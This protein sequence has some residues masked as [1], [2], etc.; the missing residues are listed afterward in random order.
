MIIAA[1]VTVA[2]LVAGTA[3][4]A[5]LSDDTPGKPSGVH[6]SASSSPK[7]TGPAV[8][9][10]AMEPD[11]PVPAGDGAWL[12]PH[13]YAT[14]AP[15]AVTG[16]HPA[17]G[18]VLWNVPLTGVICAASDTKTAAGLIAVTYAPAGSVKDRCTEIAV[19]DLN[20]GTMVWHRSIPEE[21]V[22]EGFR[23]S[24]AISDTTV[25]AGWEEYSVGYQTATGTPLWTAPASGCQGEDHR[26][27]P[28]G[29]KVVTLA[30]CGSMHKVGERDPA[31]GKMRWRFSVPGATDAW[32]VSAEP[33]VVGL[34]T[35]PE[36]GLGN[37]NGMLVISPA[38][39]LQAAIDLGDKYQ[40][41]CEWLQSRCGKVVVTQDSFYVTSRIPGSQEADEIA[42][43]DMRTGTRRWNVQL[44][45]WPEQRVLPITADASGNLIAYVKAQG[46][47]GSK[48]VSL[49]AQTGKH[50]VLLQMPD[51]KTAVDNQADDRMMSEKGTDYFHYQDGRLYLHS[52]SAVATYRGV[53]MNLVLG[54]R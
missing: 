25:A 29:R 6:T 33:L 24:V 44:K 37:A 54:T 3:L 2:A 22:K 36:L 12:T 34:T 4:W 15:E 51:G 10:A 35:N 17:S 52:K 11:A 50:T 19:I 5:M 30:R 47:V 21:K 41:G 7:P 27:V 26:G 39:K 48:V 53:V 49:S 18:K 23:T 14:G 28:S 16:Y 20:K 9:W 13:V 31:S 38:N 42:A 8:L 43:F 32:L 46:S 1:V 40:A 45:Q